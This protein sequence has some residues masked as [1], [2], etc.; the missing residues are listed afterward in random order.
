M[1]IA[2]LTA[3]VEANM[4]SQKDKQGRIDPFQVVAQAAAERVLKRIEAL[5]KMSSNPEWL[6]IDAARQAATA[7]SRL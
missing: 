7:D 1:V 3:F 2:D 6:Q 5:S 4:A